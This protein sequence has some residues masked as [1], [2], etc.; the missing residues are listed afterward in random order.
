RV[1]LLTPFFFFLALALPI[2]AQE[3]KEENKEELILIESESANASYFPNTGLFSA[4]GGVRVTWRDTVL[5][6][7]S[8]KANQKT[9]EV[10]ADGKVRIQQGDQV[11]VGEHIVYNFYT[12]SME[13]EVFRTGKAPAFASGEHLRGD[14][15]NSVYTAENA[16]I[17]TDDI[18]NPALKL[19]ASSITIVPGKYI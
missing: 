1:I 19:K 18:Y 16:F 5:V 7:D 17:T 13:T 12:R 9:G 15:S 8:V 10:V 2:L 14:L 3:K 4:T 6:A 11:W